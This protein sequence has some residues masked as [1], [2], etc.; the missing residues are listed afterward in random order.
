MR[1]TKL[2]RVSFK[3]GQPTQQRVTDF[4]RT[5]AASD[6]LQ[7]R[8]ESLPR[9]YTFFKS[10]RSFLDHYY[11]L[12]QSRNI[13]SRASGVQW[14]R[15]WHSIGYLTERRILKK[16]G[17]LGKKLDEKYFTRWATRWRSVHAT[18]PDTHNRLLTQVEEALHAVKEGSLEKHMGHSLKV[19]T[20]SLPEHNRSFKSGNGLFCSGGVIEPGTVV[21]M[22][23]GQWYIKTERG[24]RRW[25]NDTEGN[26]NGVSPYHHSRRL[27]LDKAVLDSDLNRVPSLQSNASP[28]E[29]KEAETDFYKSMAEEL[30]GQT[31]SSSDSE[32]VKIVKTAYLPFAKDLLNKTLQRRGTPHCSLKDWAVRDSAHLLIGMTQF[33]YTTHQT[34]HNRKTW[35]PRL[36]TW[37]SHQPLRQREGEQCDADALQL[38]CHFPQGAAPIPAPPAS[39]LHRVVYSP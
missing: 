7:Y 10:A 17:M 29:M 30:Q 25:H 34:K 8:T 36:C 33:L 27:F 3:S 24:L 16:E 32:I 1:T 23:P 37:T 9:H 6:E 13:I 38:P 18:I 2:L 20:S 31:A 28:D 14:K 5:S 15:D 21:T 19:R 11:L 12:Y 26:M 39:A 35:S 22:M 4:S